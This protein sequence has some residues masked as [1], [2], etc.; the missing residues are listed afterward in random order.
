MV[1]AIE[2]LN[3]DGITVL[4]IEHN[5]PFVERL[6]PRVI[7]MAL[8]TCIASGSMAELRGH[9]DVLDAYLGQVPVSA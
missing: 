1:S 9:A 8:G 3:A 7:V 2:R 5:L 6:C 4:M